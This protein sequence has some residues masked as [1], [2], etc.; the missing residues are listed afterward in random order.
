MLKCISYISASEIMVDIED[1]V[2]KETK[3]KA[4]RITA[5]LLD[6][7]MFL[8]RCEKLT[9]TNTP[10]N[11]A[12]CEI[13]KRSASLEERYVYDHCHFN[14]TT[15]VIKSCYHNGSY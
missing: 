11:E 12:S 8:D 5:S 2:I 7:K 15:T 3:V 4:N 6:V 14:V 9:R 13:D 10:Q 1:D